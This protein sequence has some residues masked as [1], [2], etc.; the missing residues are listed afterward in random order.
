MTLKAKA[1]IEKNKLDVIK[2]KIFFSI[3]GHTQRSEK[4]NREWEKIQLTLE[5][6][7]G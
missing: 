5:S 7:Q 6:C 2:I 1:T 3:K 4:G